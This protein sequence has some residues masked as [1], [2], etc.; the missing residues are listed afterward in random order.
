MGI[1]IERN[2]KKKVKELETRVKEMQYINMQIYKKAY[3][4]GYRKAKVKYNSPKP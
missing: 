4:K 2:L 1:T 3:D